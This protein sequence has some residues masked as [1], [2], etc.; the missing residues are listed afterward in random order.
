MNNHTDLSRPGAISPFPPETPIGMAYVPFQQWEAPLP[1][2]I[3][4]EKGTV[5][6]S[7]FLP[8]ERG[9]GLA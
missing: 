9:R 1:E 8:F 4:L 7:L 5:F 6:P 2:N 3:A